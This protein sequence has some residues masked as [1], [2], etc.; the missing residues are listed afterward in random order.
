M[1]ALWVVVLVAGFAAAPVLFGRLTSEAGSIDDSESRARRSRR[2]GSAA[3]TGE[4]IYA[5]ADG[6][7]ATDPGCARASTAS[8]A[9]LAALP[10]VASVTTPWTGVAAGGHPTPEAVARDGRAVGI[11]VQLRPRFGGGPAIDAVVADSAHGRRADGAGRRGTLLDDEMDAQA[12]HDLARAELLSMPVVL[13]L[14]LVVF[15]GIVAAGLPVLVAIVGVAATLGALALASLVSDVSVYSVNIVTMLGLGL[16]VDYALLLVSR[17]REE[18]A[19]DPDVEGALRRT[20]AT[21]G[22]TVAFSGLTVAASL[23]GLL[24][25]P[26]DFLRSMGLAGIC[27]VL[28]D[29]VAALTLLPAL[30]GVV[31]HR[32][33]PAR[34]RPAT[35]ACSSGW[36]ASCGGGAWS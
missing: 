25:F 6:R 36:H 18:R 16:A 21:A 20:I 26:D 29:M 10:G 11:V 3:P 14:L 4:V 8:P 28:L 33:K 17:F 24:V 15:G 27:V 7:A 1:L 22:R 12:A 30:L 9:R 2:C 34:A 5:V 35:A 19:V 13:V 23:A 32:I 31:G